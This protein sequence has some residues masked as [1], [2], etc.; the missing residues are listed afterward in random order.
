MSCIEELPDEFE[1]S[2]DVNRNQEALPFPIGSHGSDQNGT[3]P[4]L[5]PHMQSVRSHT[6]DEIVDLLKKTP[7]FMTSLDDSNGEGED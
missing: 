1:H 2:I 7:L 4:S 6:A 5:P 3:A